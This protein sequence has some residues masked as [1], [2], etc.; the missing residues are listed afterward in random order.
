MKIS[1]KEKLTPYLKLANE[2]RNYIILGVFKYG[3]KLP[4]VRTVA[5]ELG[6]NPNT[7]NKSYMLLEEEGYI[8][9]YP[10][11]GAYVM[12]NGNSM[13]ETCQA[14]KKEII[15]IKNNGVTKN[16][17]VQIIDDVYGGEND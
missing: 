17:L 11:K 1:E 5:S 8:R 15:M 6:I 16:E 7:V 14:A 3:E 4:S 12:Y 10:K 13:Q 9:T 2:Y